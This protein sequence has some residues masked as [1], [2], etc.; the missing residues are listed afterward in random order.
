MAVTSV[1][2]PQ[3]RHFGDLSD[4]GRHA[5]VDGRYGQSLEDKLEI[6]WGAGHLTRL[7]DL[8]PVAV[9]ESGDGMLR[10]AVEQIG[11]MV[12]DPID[13]IAQILRG[14][15]QAAGHLFNRY[16]HSVYE[17]LDYLGRAHATSTNLSGQRGPVTMRLAGHEAAP[18]AMLSFVEYTSM[19]LQMP[20]TFNYRKSGTS[21]NRE[22]EIPPRAGVEYQKVPVRVINSCA[23]PD[24]VDDITWSCAF[25][26]TRRRCDKAE[27]RSG[28]PT[29]Q[30]DAAAYGT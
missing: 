16:S 9:G 14:H 22:C 12:I 2:D 26:R 21:R 8:V 3:F 13:V 7:S 1:Y 30:Q 6:A 25:Q 28:L 18:P 29:E 24:L 5:R 19:R 11:V 15:V 10:V 17:V 27:L 23:N 4:H 20:D